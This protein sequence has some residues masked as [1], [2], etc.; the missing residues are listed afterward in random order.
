MEGGK[1][2]TCKQEGEKMLYNTQTLQNM[3]TKINK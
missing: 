1:E 3:Q 2:H